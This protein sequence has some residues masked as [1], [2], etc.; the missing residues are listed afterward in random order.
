M[1]VNARRHSRRVGTTNKASTWP[2]RSAAL[3]CPC[4]TP[5]PFPAHLGPFPAL[6]GAVAVFDPAMCCPTGLCGQ[7]STR[8]LTIARPALALESQGV[9]D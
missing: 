7:A 9:T 2:A 5:C 4:T 1:K 6:P 8:L 3:Q